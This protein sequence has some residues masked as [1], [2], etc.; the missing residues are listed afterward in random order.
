MP[1]PLLIFAALLLGTGAMRLVELAVSVR[2]IRA[3]PDAA[4][5]EPWLFPAM[6]SLHFGLVFAPLAEVLLLDRPFTPW[7]AALSGAVLLGATALRAWTLST[8]GKA[9]NVRVVKPEDQAIATG[10]PYRWIR[11]PNYLVV[12]LEIVSLPLFHGAW[13]A[14]IGLSA[15]NALVL[16]RRITTEEAVLMGIP[17]WR[18]AMAAKARFVPGLF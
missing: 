13:I 2:R 18:E 9:W 11:H 8:I 17:A 1:A 15:W 10:G 12:V 6:A 14:A 7:L 5:S 3:R 4:V 16:W